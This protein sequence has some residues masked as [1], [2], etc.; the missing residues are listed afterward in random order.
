M[1]LGYVVVGFGGLAL[2]A[3]LT[4]DG[5]LIAVPAV[6]GYFLAI[7]ESIA[8]LRR[9]RQ[10][11]APALLL[12]A[13]RPILAVTLLALVGVIAANG[14]LA[15]HYHPLAGAGGPAVVWPILIAL[16]AYRAWIVPSARRVA[17]LQLF[18]V[19]FAMPGV[20]G[21]M[22]AHHLPRRA[23]ATTDTALFIGFII[24]AAAGVVLDRLYASL[25]DRGTDRVPEA[26][27]RH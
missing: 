11:K 13:A 7:I 10:R 12:G 18:A 4:G 26:T 19:T 17:I 20:L 21:A 6:F 24:V 25:G 2:A 1:I 23:H 8:F 5:A 14:A 3:A 27:L 15:A 9:A 22:V 16:L